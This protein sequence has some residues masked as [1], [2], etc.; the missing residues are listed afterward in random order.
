VLGLFERY[1]LSGLFKSTLRGIVMYFQR[2]DYRDFIAET[3][4]SGIAPGNPE[5]YL[6][7][8]LIIAKK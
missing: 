4:K 2:Q 7:Y 8:G 3:R 6:G 1:G 5:E